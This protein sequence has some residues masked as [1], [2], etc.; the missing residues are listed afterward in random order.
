MAVGV[1]LR[2]WMTGGTGGVEVPLSH[3]A[4][5]SDVSLVAGLAPYL[6]WGLGSHVLSLVESL[7]A[8]RIVESKKGPS[9]S[10]KGPLVY[11]FA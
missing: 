3:K 4:R 1:H 6:A 2:A 9:R 11:I 5:W 10:G 7:A 8:V